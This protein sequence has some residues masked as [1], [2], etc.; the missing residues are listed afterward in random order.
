MTSRRLRIGYKQ[1]SRAEALLATPARRPGRLP[2][3]EFRDLDGVQRGPL[4]ELVPD[5]P[6]VQGV[7]AGEVLPNPAHVAVVG[8][9]R[10]EGHRVLEAGGVVQDPQAREDGEQL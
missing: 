4:T 2:G 3:E 1:K 10:R 5:R 6:E 7:L 9:G 8:P